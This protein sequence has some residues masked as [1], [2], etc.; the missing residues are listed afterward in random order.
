MSPATSSDGAH[1]AAAPKR[2]GKS[3]SNQP[4]P[5]SKKLLRRNQQNL[6]LSELVERTKDANAIAEIPDLK[7]FSQLPLSLM[8]QKGLSKGNFLEMT[9]IQRSSL[10]FSLCGR[11]VLGAAR[12]GS[13]KTLAFLIPVLET[14]FKATWTQLD[15]VGAIII[16]PT[17]ELALQIFEVLRKV[18]RFHNFSAGLLIGGKDLKG[19]QGRVGRMNILVCTPGRLLQHMDQTPEF[20][21]D[22]LQILVL[23]EAD[24][25]LDNGFEKTLN[26]IV[27]NLPKS[28]QTLLFSATQ[29]RS[30]RDLARLS[31]KNPEYVAVHDAAEHS[32]PKNLMQNYIVCPLPQ[33]LDVLF[34]F[35]KSHLK[36]KVLVFLSSC[37]QV[38]FVFE[39]FCKLQPGVPLM[40]LHGKQKQAKRMA[41][42]EQFCRKQDA[43]LFATDVAARGLDFPAVDWV[44]QVDCPED[45][46]TYIHRVGRTAR[47]ESAGKALLLLLPSE[48]DGMLEALEQKKV[49]ISEIKINPAKTVSIRKQLSGLCSQSPDIKYL[50]Q[51][52]FI[53]YLRSVYLQANKKIF[54]VGQ[55]PIDEFADSLGLPG[56]PRIK[57]VKRSQAKNASRQAQ[58]AMG[59][60]SDGETGDASRPSGSKIAKAAADQ[61]D[62]DA[63]DSDTEDA[64]AAAKPKKP[65][66]K[67][68]KMFEKK[69]LTVLS[70]HY[71]K[72]KE[73]SESD[74]DD[75]EFLSL[76]RANHDLDEDEL[77]MAAPSKLNHRQLLKTK[78]KAIKER[79]HS[80]KLVFDEEG[81]PVLDF[82]LETLDEFE[83]KQDI[84]SRQ[85]EYLEATTAKMREADTIDRSIE[86]ERLKE[87]KRL[88]RLKEKNERRAESGQEVQVTLGPAGSD[89]EDASGGDFDG[90]DDSG[91][92][93]ESDDDGAPSGRY[94]VS[95][96][97]DEDGEDEGDDT[98]DSDGDE[99]GD[100]EMQLDLSEDTPAPRRPLP[101][102]Q[103]GNK[104]RLNGADAVAVAS[105]PAASKPAKRTKVI[106]DLNTQSLEDLALQLLDK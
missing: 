47:Y 55:L 6:E 78:T 32:T 40:C 11:D 33:K 93:Y 99:S 75:Q 45:A 9:E 79:G 72:L 51:K 87:K 18:G 3:K 61:G 15:G 67:I 102:P 12:T 81:N 92:E 37:K 76:K 44:V 26:A 90:G 98:Y 83:K 27:A 100:E 74:S 88:K 31:L 23:D 43:C 89:Y 57:F 60:D 64:A 70:E 21:C 8:T 63:D 62:S 104:R 49:P 50:G 24:R 19:E 5:E 66:T 7:L 80:T 96:Y 84:A 68:D 13:G 30:V 10:P 91:S 16:S 65:K 2:R 48:K 59:Q 25:I 38:R 29:T 85:R 56:A 105:K 22:N 46:A 94:N 20:S 86:R 14:L 1:A 69:N 34:S 82:K 52:A 77:P 95:R 58:A 42:F 73:Q 17:R 54:D 41:I 101:P 53:C 4:K 36:Q 39:T 106:T 71:A 35:L 28:R 103:A 97:G